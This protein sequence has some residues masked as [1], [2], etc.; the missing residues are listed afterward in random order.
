[1][2]EEPKDIDESIDENDPIVDD[3]TDD[4]G[5]DD[6]NDYSSSAPMDKHADL[7]KDLTD[8]D[9]SIKRRIENWLGLEW[10]EAKKDYIQRY[11]AIINLRG[12]KWAIGFLGTYLNKTN[13][14]TNI[15]EEEYKD[16]RKDI[17][18]TVWVVFMTSDDFGVQSNAN[19]YRLATE[20][21]HSAELVLMGAGDGKYTKFMATATN[22][23]ESINLSPQQNMRG[24]LKKQGMFS[25]I[26]NRLLGRR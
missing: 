13:I 7:L 8:F 15:S 3:N 12:A 11:E 19:W 24:E 9:P 5:L 6:F 14:L 16:L 4:F 2:T 23:T 18:N 25:N 1:M 26:K 21:Q 10:D 17:I 22:R 20:L